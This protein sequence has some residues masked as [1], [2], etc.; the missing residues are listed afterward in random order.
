MWASVATVLAVTLFLGLVAMLLV[1]SLPGLERHPANKLWAY[2][3]HIGGGTLALVIAPFQFVASVRNRFRSYHRGAG[4]AFVGG[5]AAAFLGFWGMQPTDPDIFFASQAMAICL[6]M[7]AMVAA[8]LA[9]RRR[10]FLTH[11]HNMTR[12]LTLAAYFVVVRLID[13][14][15]MGT[16]GPWLSGNEDAGLAHSD[17]I[18]WVVPLVAVEAYYGL[19]WSRVLRARA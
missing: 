3:I 12:A 7:G 16:I 10:L 13:Q 5:S 1:R 2:W 4:Y 11:S 14:A 17:W 6:W 15:G 19:Q 9:A 18:A 8:T